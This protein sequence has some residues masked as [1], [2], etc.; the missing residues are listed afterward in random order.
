MLGT[1]ATAMPI[2]IYSDAKEAELTGPTPQ[3]TFAKPI[4]TPSDVESE[5][6]HQ[7]AATPPLSLVRRE[8]TLESESD[9]TP[10]LFW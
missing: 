2:Y 4:E 10:P 3:A 5:G 1:A 8:T 6:G 9:C 7:A